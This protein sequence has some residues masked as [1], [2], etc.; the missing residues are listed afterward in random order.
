MP[1]LKVCLRNELELADPFI[2]ASSHLTASKDAFEKLSVVCPSAVTLKTIS[3]KHGGAKYDDHKGKRILRPITNWNGN[4]IGLYTD[5]PKNTE[6]FGL[7]IAHDM[8]KEAKRIL[9]SSK[10]GISILQNE[11]YEDIKKSIGDGYDYVEL[12]LKYSLRLNEDRKKEIVRVIEEINTD[13]E[14]F[15]KVFHDNPKFIKF[16][17]EMEAFINELTCSLFFDMIE[18]YNTVIIV[19]NSKK[20]VAPPSYSSFVNPNP[21][22]NGVVVGDYLFLDTYNF[23]NRIN[24]IYAD[25]NKLDCFEVSASGGISSIGEIIDCIGL[26]VNTFQICSLITQRGI[27]SIEMLRRQISACLEYFE[28]K[29]FNEFRD[30]IILNPGKKKDLYKIFSDKPKITENINKCAPELMNKTLLAESDKSDL[31]IHDYH[32]SENQVTIGLAGTNGTVLS[33]ALTFC[34]ANSVTNYITKLTSS[35]EAVNGEYDSIII[36]DAY[37]DDFNIK[38]P[39]WVSSK[40]GN[41]CYSLMSVASRLKDINRVFLFKSLSSEKMK[42]EVQK[43]GNFDFI[44]IEPSE[45][46]P[47][48]I[49]WEN[50][51]GIL[52][53]KPITELYSILMPDYLSK[54]W[55]SLH[56]FSSPIWLIAKKENIENISADIKRLILN[57]RSKP[58]VMVKNL[59]NHGF[60]KYLTDFLHGDVST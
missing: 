52:A 12:N 36:S 23:I 53:K 34:L 14:E 43:L 60:D 51:M 41:A 33:Y 18:K 1:N 37:K 54:K 57:I 50:D 38:H 59:L 47:L 35:K 16:S 55:R 9:P 25:K 56:D 45:L 4:Y 22:Q 39:E 26:G 21:L 11:D 2:I 48:L 58:D 30:L 28:C 19:A 32:E 24:Q 6:L 10:I 29:N 49:S 13:C 8:I 44:Y 3:K 20:C 46:A 17:R 27:F 31:L 7:S 40:L 15:C 5:G 42:I